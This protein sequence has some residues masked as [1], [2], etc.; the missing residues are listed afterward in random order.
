MPY[1]GVEQNLELIGTL[2]K[3]ISHIPE[4]EQTVG[5]WGRVNSALDP[6]PIQMYENTINYRSE[7]ALN[8]DGKRGR[9]KVDKDGAFVLK[10][11]VFI[12]LPMDFDV[13]RLTV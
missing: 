7:Y 2:D 5:K 11:V 6:A 1:T 13:Y 12:S 3:R 9:F 10:T 8:E 4:V